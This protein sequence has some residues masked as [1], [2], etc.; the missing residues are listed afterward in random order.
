MPAQ[1]TGELIGDIHNAG[2]KI[3]DVAEEAKLNPKYVSQ[4]LHGKAVSQKAESK[5]RDALDRLVSRMG[6]DADG[7]PNS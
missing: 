4:L 6:E 1:W 5:L 2:L 3:R 7:S